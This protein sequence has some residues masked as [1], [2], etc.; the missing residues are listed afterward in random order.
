MWDEEELAAGC[1]CYHQHWT[2]CKVI[3]DNE[4]IVG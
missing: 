2:E 1:C 3:G 4:F